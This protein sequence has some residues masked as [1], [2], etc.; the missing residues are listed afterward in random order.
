MRTKLRS[1][2]HEGDRDFAK[3]LDFGIA[4]LVG[5]AETDSDDGEVP[6]EPP[7]HGLRDGGG[8]GGAMEEVQRCGS[9]AL[10]AVKQPCHSGKGRQP[11]RQ[12]PAARIQVSVKHSST[13]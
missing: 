4:K 2:E 10:P 6:P 8:E 9:V 7:E 3:I 12:A 11:G 5:A 13:V 1:R